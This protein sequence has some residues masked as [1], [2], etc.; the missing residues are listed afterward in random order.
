MG[1]RGGH[2]D[3]Y[4]HTAVDL[5]R[6]ARSEA[7][8]A[9]SSMP[10]ELFAVCYWGCAI[11]SFVDCADPQAGMWAWDPNPAPDD[12]IGKA[13][14]PQSMTFGEWLVRWVE[15]RL[16]QPALVHDPDTGEWRG[17]TDEEYAAWMA[18]A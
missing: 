3:D 8:S 15:G 16:H 13:L 18:E 5:Y 10:A 4:R 17:A 1:V 2:G 9:W 6:Q 14:F 12:D 7:G 11:Y